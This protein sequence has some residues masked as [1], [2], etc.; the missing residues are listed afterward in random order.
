MSR[1]AV[2]RTYSG[3]LA[4]TPVPASLELLFRLRWNSCSGL[5]E[6]MFFRAYAFQDQKNLITSAPARL[7]P[8]GS[9]RYGARPGPPQPG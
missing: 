5:P 6:F 8:G 4:G 7:S 9:S 1:L 2:V 3:D